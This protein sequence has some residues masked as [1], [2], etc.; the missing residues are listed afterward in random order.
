MSHF[1]SLRGRDKALWADVA[2]G[3]GVEFYEPW[4]NDVTVTSLGPRAA[5]LSLLVCSCLGIYTYKYIY[6]YICI[7]IYVY[8]NINI[9]V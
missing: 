5:G 1:R 4:A 9:Y 6:L 2:L 3:H 7:Y 8:I